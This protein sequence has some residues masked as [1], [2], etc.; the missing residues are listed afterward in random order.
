MFSLLLVSLPVLTALSDGTY[1]FRVRLTDKTG[2]SFTI[3]VAG[4]MIV[5]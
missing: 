1:T 4:G 2:V 3:T 5:E